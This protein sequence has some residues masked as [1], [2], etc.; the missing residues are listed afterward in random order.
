MAEGEIRG[1]IEQIEVH[2][3]KSYKGAHT[4]GPFKPFTAVVGPNGSGTSQIGRNPTV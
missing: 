4:I 2:N 3:F 1:F